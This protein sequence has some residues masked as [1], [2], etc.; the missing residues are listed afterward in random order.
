MENKK[1]Y[2][3]RG[4]ITGLIIY[5]LAVLIVYLT[6]IESAFGPVWQTEMMAVYVLPIIPFISLFV[7]WLYGKIKNRNRL[8]SML[9][10]NA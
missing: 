8:S 6:N 10:C 3:L 9:I 1:R 2:W 5:L 7:G 4:L